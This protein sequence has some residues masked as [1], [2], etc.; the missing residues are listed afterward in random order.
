VTLGSPLQFM[1]NETVVFGRIIEGFRVFKMIEKCDT[2]N[3][4]PNPPIIIQETGIH[5]IEVKKMTSKKPAGEEE[6]AP[7]EN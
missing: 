4:Y 2:V 3:E 7:V 5:S 6:E 1:D